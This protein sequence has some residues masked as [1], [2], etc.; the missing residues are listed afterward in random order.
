MLRWRILINVL[1]NR[2]L[3]R[4]GGR[5]CFY[6]RIELFSWRLVRIVCFCDVFNW[7]NVWNVYFGIKWKRIIYYWLVCG[8]GEN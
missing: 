1:R 2:I 4:I 7:L 6:F 5:K 3:W 8:V